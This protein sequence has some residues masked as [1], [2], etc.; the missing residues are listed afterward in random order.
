MVLAAERHLRIFDAHDRVG[1]DRRGQKRVATDDDIVADLR[2]TAEQ[3]GVCVDDDV[4]A[5]LR[6]AAHIRVRRHTRGRERAERRA[7]IELDVVADDRRLADD[8]ARTVVDEEVFADLRAGVDVDTVC[9]CAYSD[10]MRG[11]IAT[12]FSYS[13]CAMR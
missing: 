12:L 1:R 3:R 2:R 6:V 13:S 7:L 9:E 11:I 10:I 4:V 8:D 5:D